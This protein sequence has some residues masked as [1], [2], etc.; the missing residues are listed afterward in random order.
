MRVPLLVALVLT[1]TPAAALPEG[2]NGK[3]TAAIVATAMREAG[4]P[5]TPPVPIRSLPPCS[6]RPHVAALNGSWSVAELRCDA[7]AWKRALRTTAPAVQASRTAGR[8][9]GQETDV[10]LARPL[11]RGT[12]LAA[13]DI[14]APDEPSLADREWRSAVIG[15]RLK[16]ALGPGQ[17]VLPRH[18]EPDWLV[19]R[20]GPVAVRV[21]V[22]NIEVLAPG[23]ALA[24]AG[25]GDLVE[26]RNLSSGAILRATVTARNMAE[27]RPNMR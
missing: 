25:L 14:V 3:E 7:P 4:V 20:G 8:D 10:T 26:V 23:E 15:R 19:T 5:G 16:V 27:V 24:D 22:G 11:A 6:H 9:A 21:A 17:P 12:V 13:S 2:L 1:A 18:L